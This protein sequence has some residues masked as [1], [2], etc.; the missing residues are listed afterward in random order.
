[1]AVLSDL[2]WLRSVWQEAG[3]PPEVAVQHA[4]DR[5]APLLRA[6]RHGDGALAVFNGGFEETAEAVDRTLG[7]ADVKGRPQMNAPHAGYQRCVA[8]RT[9]LVADAGPPAPAGLD[10][11]PFAGTLSFE[12]S[13]GR[14]RLVVNCGSG[15]ASPSAAWAEA[16][17]TTAAHSTLVLHDTN[18]TELLAEGSGGRRPREVLAGRQEDEDGNHWLD[19]E[20][21]GYLAVFG[22]PHRRPLEPARGLGREFAVGR[23]RAVVDAGRVAGVD[24]GMETHAVGDAGR[25]GRQGMVHA[26]SDCA[27]S[28]LARSFS[29]SPCSQR[30]TSS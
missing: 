10:P 27:H 30:S 16:S 19:L 2:I 13:V 24:R 3:Q 23:D 6:L 14:Q 20:H 21:D 18:S 26:V 7:L 25:L 17:R 1:M 8:G 29:I 28:A 22:A 12:L 15:L 9:V 11:P 4:I 5:M